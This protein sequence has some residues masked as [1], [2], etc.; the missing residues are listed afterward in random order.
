VV[1]RSRSRKLTSTL[2]VAGGSAHPTAAPR[3]QTAKSGR[4]SFVG[5]HLAPVPLQNLR[6]RDPLR[7]TPIDDDAFV[8]LGFDAAGPLLGVRSV[9]EGSGLRRESGASDL[10]SPELAALLDGRHRTVLL[11][12]VS[13]GC[14]TGTVPE[15]SQKALKATIQKTTAIQETS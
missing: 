9:I 2:R 3:R 13:P 4:A 7:D 15:L 1:F 14:A 12:G 6:E 5:R 11:N 10:D 8:D